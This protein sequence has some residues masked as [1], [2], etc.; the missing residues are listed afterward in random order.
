M[1]DVKLKQ[2]LEAARQ[3]PAPGAPFDFTRTVLAALRRA[4]PRPARPSLLEQLSPLFPR[5]AAASLLVIGLS[6][7]SAFYFAEPDAGSTADF[8]QLTEQWFFSQ[9]NS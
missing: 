5:L 6:V 2:L 8:N 9:D 7:A 1:N 3:E 4:A